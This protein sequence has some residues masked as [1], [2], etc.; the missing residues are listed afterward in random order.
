MLLHAL[1]SATLILCVSLGLSAPVARAVCWVQKEPATQKQTGSALGSF[2]Q[3]GDDETAE[4]KPD[5]KKDSKA[6]SMAAY[7]D[8]LAKQKEGKLADAQAA[9]TKASELDPNAPEPVRAHALLL[10]RLGRPKQAEQMAQKA[11]AL[12]AN[13]HETRLQ[14]ALLLRGRNDPKNAIRLIEEALNSK[15]LQQKSEEALRIHKVRGALYQE[16]GAPQRAAESYEVLLNALERP[17]E[18]GLDFRQ[19]QVYLNDRV[20]GYEGIG[21]MMLQIGRYDEAIVA[22]KGLAKSRKNQPG[23]HQLYLATA[24]YR[25]DLLDESAKNLDR[26]FDSNQRNEESLQLLSDLYRAT[27]RQSEIPN[28]LEE[29]SRD[30]PDAST[31]RLFLGKYFIAQGDPDKATEVY[32]KIIIDS[33]DADA[34]LGLVRVEILRADAA[35]LTKRIARAIRARISLQELIPLK[36]NIANDAEFAAAVVA[37]GVDSLGNS[38]K[39]SPLETFFYSELAEDLEMV[40]EEEQ[41]LAATLKLNPDPRI[42]VDAMGRLGFNLLLQDR[43][44]ESARTYR[45]LLGIPGLPGQQQLISL[46][47]LSQAEA[48]NKN[49]NDAI[50][51][52]E[53][54]LKMSPQNPELTYQLGWIQLQADK[55]EEAEKSLKAAARLA[56]N[57]PSTESRASMLLGALY[58]QTRRWDEAIKTYEQILE[59]PE[60][61][62]ELVR[63]SRVSLSNAYV[64]MGDLPNGQRILEEVYEASPNDPGVNNDLGYLYADEGT[65]LEKAE[66]MIRLAVAAEPDNPAYLDSLGWVL[67]KLE[68]FKEAKSVLE[69]SNA[70]PDYQDS[71][72]IE[73]LGDVQQALNEPDIAVKTWQKALDIEKE[74]PTANQDVIERLTRKLSESKKTDEAD[75]A[76]PTK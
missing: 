71:T 43:Y 62:A 33:G 8:G 38:E 25:K 42:G 73:H 40:K 18:F 47:R 46:Y 30:T 70:D 34:H 53:A 41:L 54:A 1:K 28:R 10:M 24:Q 52:I 27:G 32:E 4:L 21:Q 44:A 74:S 31:V 5:S 51:A 23:T 12:D 75:N 15:T 3:P 68:K 66:K 16:A 72:I 55:Y 63:R 6:E 50:L 17:E 36:A 22:F 19:Q 9:F 45:N 20:S 48:F 59:I 61:S 14:L 65:N 57:D 49:Y 37:A 69:K 60:L 39:Q 67:F 35:A 2:R 26:Y 76:T 11:I 7:M 64:Q 56:E 29:L 13:D 58:T